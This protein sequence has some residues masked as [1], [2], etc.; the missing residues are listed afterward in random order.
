MALC[1][2]ASL[3]DR[4]SREPTIIPATIVEIVC[5]VSLAWG[6]A[7]EMLRSGRWRIALIT[8]LVALVGVLL[9]IAALTAGR[10]PR[11]AS[12]DVRHGIMQ[13]LIITSIA[14]L[15]F[16]RKGRLGLPPAAG[17]SIELRTTSR[18]PAI[19]APGGN[20]RSFGSILFEEGAPIWRMHVC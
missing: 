6:A 13:T 3:S 5:G 19:P 1:T 7:A 14:I 4:P 15:F 2:Q 17:A 12:N 8:H 11:T 16:G 18:S 20:S 10:G 9:G